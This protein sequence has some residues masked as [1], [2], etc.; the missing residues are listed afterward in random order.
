MTN[1]KGYTVVVTFKESCSAPYFLESGESLP[2]C[3]VENYT[4]ES[5]EAA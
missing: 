1:T 2:K 4:V 5:V 3:W